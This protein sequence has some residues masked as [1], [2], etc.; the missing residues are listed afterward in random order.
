MDTFDTEGFINFPDGIV[1]DMHYIVVEVND[2][3]SVY[4]VTVPNTMSLGRGVFTG[5]SQADLLE[6]F[7]D[8]VGAPMRVATAEEVREYLKQ[9]AQSAAMDDVMR[10]LE[11]DDGA[12]IV[13]H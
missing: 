2:P 1:A 6:W 7:S 5:K 4:A 9:K 11:G 13:F 10:E 3:T 12:D 8:E